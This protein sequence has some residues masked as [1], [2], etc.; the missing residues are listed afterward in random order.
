MREATHTLK[1]LL[2]SSSVENEASTNTNV[3]ALCTLYVRVPSYVD[4][5]VG[6]TDEVACMHIN[7]PGL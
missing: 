6:K 2:I 7:F 1:E 4:S 5:Y 3:T